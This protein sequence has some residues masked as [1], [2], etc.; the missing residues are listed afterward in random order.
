MHNSVLTQPLARSAPN[1]FPNVPL[2][3]H[4]ALIHKPALALLYWVASST[5]LCETLALLHWTSFLP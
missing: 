4:P 3:D 5:S 1:I 2:F